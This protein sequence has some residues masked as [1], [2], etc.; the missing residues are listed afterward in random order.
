MKRSILKSSLIALLITGGISEKLF[1][2]D[3]PDSDNEDSATESVTSTQIA[4]QPDIDTYVMVVDQRGKTIHSDLVTKDN[5][6]EKKYDFSKVTEGLYTFIT[7]TDHKKVERT[8]E[9]ENSG[10][11]V[12]EEQK[13]YYP[14]FSVEGDY[15]SVN[16]LNLNKE[17]ISIVLE[18]ATS[19]Y[20]KESSS[21]VFAYGKMI[22]L[23]KLAPGKYTVSLRSG[24]TTY[25]YSFYR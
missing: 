9:V 8:F 7:K 2:A 22:N 11:K 14:S 23:Q 20:F 3:I 4:V 24:K 5:L 16:Y 6:I 10:V 19:R 13:V 25:G 21:N 18:D 12:V 17:D 15:L 1:A